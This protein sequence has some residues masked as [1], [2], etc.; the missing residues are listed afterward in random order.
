MCG[1]DP[2][3]SPEIFFSWKENLGTCIQVLQQYL[4]YPRK[5][6]ARNLPIPR[7]V[8]SIEAL[9]PQAL[10]SGFVLLLHTVGQYNYYI[11]PPGRVVYMPGI[12][13]NINRPCRCTP[14]DLVDLP[15]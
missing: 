9:I 10:P 6:W 4:L 14:S 7:F 12:Y 5:Q 1:F 2:H 11:Q 3:S 8:C 15:S 13:G